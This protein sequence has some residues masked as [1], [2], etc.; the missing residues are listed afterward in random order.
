VADVLYVLEIK[1]NL[2]LVSAMEN[3]GY[4]ISFQD[5]QVLIRPNT[6]DIDSARVL[7]VREGKVYRLQGKP[8][9]GSKGILD[10]GSMSVTEDK[11]E[12]ASKGEQRS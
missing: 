12:E 11:E 2:L 9:S 5:G 6:F 1:M 10:N 3:N 8:V 7:G 4:A